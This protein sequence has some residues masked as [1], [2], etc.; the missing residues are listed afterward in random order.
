MKRLIAVI[1]AAVVSFQITAPSMAQQGTKPTP[2]AAPGATPTLPAV[3]MVSVTILYSFSTI[4]KS[5]QYMEL[6][7]PVP[8]ED[9]IQKIQNRFSYAP[10]PSQVSLDPLTGNQFMYMEGGPRG[11]VPMQVRLSF[12][13]Q[14]LEQRLE[15]DVV[16]AA[17]AGENTGQGAAATSM[18][19]W[20]GSAPGAAIDDAL[21]SKSAS[22]VAGRRTPYEKARAL[23]DFII[24]NIQD[25][26]NPE[27]PAETS[28][29]DV[30]ATLKNQRGTAVDMAATFVALC[31]AA[32]IPA[33]NVVGFKLPQRVRQGVLSG[34]HGWAEFWVEGAGWIPV[35][36][37]EGKRSV[38][39]RD[40]YFGSLD[41]NRLA[42][43]RD[44]DITMIPPQKAGPVSVFVGAYWEGNK[45]AM[46][47]PPMQVEFTELNQVPAPQTIPLTPRNPKPQG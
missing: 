21:K 1:L 26:E 12:D 4:P 16:M 6:W 47:A 29:I 23:Y 37:A 2:V 8:I 3:R 44:R 36:P 39:R 28:N 33:R 34:Q 22:I 5:V 15:P 24:A 25:T 17:R 20:L 46:P 43:S 41:P 35:D 42:I 40:Y 7:L 11:G 9:E 30:A 14:R 32:G 27:M 38:S 45:E 13:A 19:R 18:Y 31:R 10:Y